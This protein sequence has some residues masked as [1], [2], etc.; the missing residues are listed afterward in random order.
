MFESP[1]C[2]ADASQHTIQKGSSDMTRFTWGAAIELAVHVDQQQRA[3][4]SSGSFVP[5]QDST[6][7]RDQQVV[8]EARSCTAETW[9]KRHQEAP[10][11]IKLNTRS[12]SVV[13]KPECPTDDSVQQF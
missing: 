8:D 12:L 9:P 6:R 5:G 2:D 1:T 10:I 13:Q 7:T 11:T 4:S 3:S